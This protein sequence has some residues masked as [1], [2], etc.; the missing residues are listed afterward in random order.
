MK[1]FFTLI[2]VVCVSG[3]FTSAAAQD[4]EQGL[5]V[6]YKFEN[7]LVEEKTGQ[8][9]E[10]SG[11][12]TYA[13]GIE[14]QAIRFAF[15]DNYFLTPAERI[16]PGQTPVSFAMY[17][18]HRTGTVGTQRYNY[19]QQLDGGG[20]TGRATLY[21]QR[22]DSPTNPDTIISFVG[23]GTSSSNYKMTEDGRWFHL[24]LTIQPAT[25]EFIF[26]VNGVRTNRDT[27]PKQVEPSTGSYIVGHHKGLA[28]TT[29]TFDGLM[30][31]LRMYDRVLTPAEV[32]LLASE[33]VGLRETPVEAAMELSPNPSNVGQ[34]LRINLDPSEFTHS[35]A[36]DL[37]VF[38]VAG[39][40]VLTRALDVG[41]GQVSVDHDLVSG[42]YM[43]MLTNGERFASAKLTIQD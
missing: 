32:R 30:D 20:E 4:L 11:T 29:H 19:L 39:R 9:A 33:V 31:D 22:P 26:Y 7:N 28:N 14:G 24:A 5:K 27:M 16:V 41:S 35:G 2:T 8:T 37:R 21:L 17:V 25:G 18:N 23:N 34:A 3:L 13:E 1:S 40:V 36:V 6:H 15:P 42:M 10:T 12:F 43:V 38:D